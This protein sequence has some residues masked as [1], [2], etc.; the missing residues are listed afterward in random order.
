MFMYIL[1][2]LCFDGEERAWML[3]CVFFICIMQLL[4]GLTICAGILPVT[5]RKSEAEVHI[6][7]QRASERGANF[8]E[9]SYVPKLVSKPEN[10]SPS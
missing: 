9:I 4:I 1:C 3:S 6:L 7:D 2:V 5:G 8:G 10:S